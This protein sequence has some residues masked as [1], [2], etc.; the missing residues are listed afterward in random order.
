MLGMRIKHLLTKKKMTWIELSQMTCF[1]ISFLSQLDRRKSS[2]TFESVK[3]ISLALDVTP[4]YFFDES[5]GI[6]EPIVNRGSS[7]CNQMD[8]HNIYYQSLSKSIDNPA[9]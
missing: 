1:S 2:A 4:G 5:E 6:K 3:I 8:R 9:F 7:E